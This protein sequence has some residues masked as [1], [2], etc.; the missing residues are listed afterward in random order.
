MENT[1]EKVIKDLEKID[2][3]YFNEVAISNK[4]ILENIFGNRGIID[5]LLILYC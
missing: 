1:F 5:L 2:W 4:K 3:K